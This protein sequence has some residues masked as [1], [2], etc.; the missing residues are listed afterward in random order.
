MTTK[1]NIVLV[2]FMGTGKSAVGKRLASRLGMAFTDMD[3]IIVEREGRPVTRIFAE[4]GEPYFRACERALTVEL[5][6]A[7]G[8]VIATGGGIVIDPDNV[9]DFNRT[10]FVVCLTATPETILQRVQHDTHR[11]LLADGDKLRKITDLLD[12]RRPL[13][14]AIP[15]RV[16]TSS[17]PI[18]AVVNEVIHRYQTYCAD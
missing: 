1:P 16:D 8:R 3:A 17:L 9:R 5:S 10:G 2:G 15:C 13:Y 7:A 4:D 6:E 12:K 18:T 11:P 14:E